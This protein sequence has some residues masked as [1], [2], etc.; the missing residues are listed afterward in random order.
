MVDT[1]HQVV[2][3]QGLAQGSALLTPIQHWFFEQ[4][5]PEPHH[6]NQALLLEVL[7]TLDGTLLEQALQHLVSHH[8]ALRLS[9]TRTGSGWEQSHMV[10]D[11]KELVSYYDLSGVPVSEQATLLEA[12]ATELQASIDLTQGPLMRVELFELGLRQSKRLLWVIHHLVVD[13]V[14]WRILLEDLQTA[15]DQLSRGEPVQLPPKTTSFQHWAIQ[16][17]T[18]AQTA[19]VKSEIA[20]WQAHLKPALSDLPADYATVADAN[21]EASAHTVEVLLRPEETQALLQEVPKAYHTQIQ[22]ALLT[23]L[24]QACAPWTGKQHLLVDLEG[25]GREDLFE[26]VD[27]S[28]TVGWFTSLYPLRLVLAEEHLSQPG[29]ALKAIK[30]QVRQ[31]P[32]H[33]LGYGL[34]R[35]LCQAPEV[36]AHMRALPQAELSFNYLGQ[37]D[38]AWA[39]GGVFRLAQAAIGPLHGLRGKRCYLLEIT[40]L[41]VGGQLRVEWRYSRQVYRQETIEEL[42]R[43]YLEILL[44][45]IEHCLAPEAGGFTPSDFPEAGLS[46]EELDEFVLELSEHGE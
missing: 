46:Q 6:W 42:A 8:D 44:T 37:F 41:I 20:Y 26:G 39:E 4:E 22:E 35:Y 21:T 7:P 32:Q 2:A 5:L 25:H 27:L 14:S 13:G 30:E 12:R 16:L 45:L 31:V 40:A 18:Y 17:S 15:Y 33:G 36:A 28:R 19:R 11:G 1:A 24:V 3:E 29:E 38:Q 9:F 10:P 23:A 43:R 34:L